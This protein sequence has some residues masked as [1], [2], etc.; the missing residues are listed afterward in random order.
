VAGAQATADNTREVAMI[1]KDFEK[2]LKAAEKKIDMLEKKLKNQSGAQASAREN[3]K[4]MEAELKAAL[5]ESK[6]L[7]IKVEKFSVIAGEA[8]TLAT[9]CDTLKHNL[10]EAMVELDT[11]T[12]KYKK[13]QQIRKRL[14]NELEDIKGKVRVYARIRPLSRTE[15]A[16]EVNRNVCT[17]I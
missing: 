3:V 2:K 5:K 4:E 14:N 6:E 12:D 17:N 7:Q 9:K 13:E 16:D 10:K 11:L 8:A 1:K 15:L